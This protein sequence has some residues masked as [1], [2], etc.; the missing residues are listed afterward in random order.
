MKAISQI[1]RSVGLSVS[2][3][4]EVTM[5]TKN[6]HI[7]IY[8]QKRLDWSTRFWLFFTKL[9]RD[10][11]GMLCYWFGDETSKF[12]LENYFYSSFF[13]KLPYFSIAH[14]R[15]FGHQTSFNWAWPI[16][17]YAKSNL[18]HFWQKPPSMKAISQIIRSVGLFCFK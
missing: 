16:F 17:L 6:K 2:S 18:I 5:F 11:V 14:V 15:N 1:I 10:V 4:P 8:P 3:R 13:W 7:F 12:E 9:L